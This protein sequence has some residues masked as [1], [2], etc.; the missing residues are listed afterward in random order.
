MLIGRLIEL[1]DWTADCGLI[2]LNLNRP[3]T[4][5]APPRPTLHAV[6]EAGRALR[7][8]PAAAFAHPYPPTALAFSPDR[9]GAAPDLL[10]SC[11]DHVRLWRLGPGGTTLEALLAAGPD[12]GAAAPLT[13]M[14]WCE[15]DA[16]RLVAA[17][18]DTT[19]TVWDVERGTVEARLIGARW[20]GGLVA[21]LGVAGVCGFGLF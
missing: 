7:A 1:L 14:D 20:L 15:A 9:S 3:T 13:A 6:D 5:P 11:G 12:R 19:C 21:V 18:V 17:S 2:K 10:A 8:D 16:R 4:R